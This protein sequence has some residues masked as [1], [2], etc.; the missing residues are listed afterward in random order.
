MLPL[1]TVLQHLLGLF[2]QQWGLSPECPRS[3]AKTHGS[4]LGLKRK[5]RGGLNFKCVTEKRRPLQ[6]T[7]RPFQILSPG[8]KQRTNGLTHRTR[9]QWGDGWLIQ[10]AHTWPPLAADAHRR[11]Q[12]KKQTTNGRLAAAFKLA[13][14]KA[15]PLLQKAVAQPDTAEAALAI[16]GISIHAVI[17]TRPPSKWRL[18]K[19]KSIVV[20]QHSKQLGRTW[21]GSRSKFVIWHLR[22]QLS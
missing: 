20:N 7:R 5:S 12:N 10:I 19:L 13:K 17:T 16:P 22:E 8:E 2:G 15:G 11:K 4:L 21:E 3:E 1:F 14:E 6:L 9:T 18:G